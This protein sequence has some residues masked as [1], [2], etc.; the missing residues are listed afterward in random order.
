MQYF[1]HFHKF[2]WSYLFKTTK[3]QLNG[4]ASKSVHDVCP[5]FKPLKVSK[6]ISRL[7][8]AVMARWVKPNKK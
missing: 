5:T 1:K 6:H 4:S 2:L 8:V 3:F 7:A